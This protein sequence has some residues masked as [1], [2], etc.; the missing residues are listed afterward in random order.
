MSSAPLPAH[1]RTVSESVA[2]I[3]TVPTETGP[4]LPALP[5]SRRTARLKYPQHAAAIEQPAAPTSAGVFQMI[6]PQ[7]NLA[8]IHFTADL[9]P[10]QVGSR[11]KVLGHQSSG[12]QV[13]GE[14]EIVESFPGSATVRPLGQLDL[15]RLTRDTVIT[16]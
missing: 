11:L 13:T 2:P 14:L 9:L 15:A 6:D 4:V 5:S 1:K 10:M 16:R 3:P 8:H 7:R 12:W